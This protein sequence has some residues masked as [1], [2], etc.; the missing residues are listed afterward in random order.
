[1]CLAIPGTIVEISG[2]S[3]IVDYGG[4]K[5]TACASLFPDA[6]I[7]DRAL[8]HAGFVIQILSADEGEELEK[9]VQ[10][11]LAVAYEQD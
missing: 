8:V 4:T 2:D 3:A 7:G 9:L 5:R 10:E 6:Q 11:T 1:M